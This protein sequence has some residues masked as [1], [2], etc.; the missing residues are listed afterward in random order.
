MSNSSK[1]DLKAREK[2]GY[3]EHC[4]GQTNVTTIRLVVR[5]AILDP[6]S[7]LDFNSNTKDYI[8]VTPDDIH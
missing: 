3:R 6:S 1:Q 7:R 5:I 4:I 8:R 2:I